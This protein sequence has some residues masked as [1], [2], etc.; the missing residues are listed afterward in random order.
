MVSLSELRSIIH[1][2]L[3]VLCCFYGVMAGSPAGKVIL[4]TVI[5]NAGFLNELLGATP[6]VI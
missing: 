6:T 1:Q 2:F 5:E 3:S 4:T